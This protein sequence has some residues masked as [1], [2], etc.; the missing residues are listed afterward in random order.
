MLDRVSPASY[1]AIIAGQ[2]CWGIF[3]L[4]LG[5]SILSPFGFSFWH[6]GAQGRDP[7][8]FKRRR[9]SVSTENVQKEPMDRQRLSRAFAEAYRGDRNPTPIPREL[10]IAISEQTVKSLF[11]SNPQFITMIPV[12]AIRSERSFRD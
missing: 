11:P 3:P 9:E 7:Q 5:R 2:S 8:I 1:R 12:S 6:A 10:M 4:L